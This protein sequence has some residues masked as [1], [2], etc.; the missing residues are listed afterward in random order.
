MH[1][2]DAQLYRCLYLFAPTPCTQPKFHIGQWVRDADGFIGKI[3]GIA[4]NY[5]NPIA[6]IGWCYFVRGNQ[7]NAFSDTATENELTLMPPQE[8]QQDV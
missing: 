2:P 6:C 5:P 3:N 8:D 1:S 4:W 7:P